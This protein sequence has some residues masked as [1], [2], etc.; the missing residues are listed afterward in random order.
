MAPRV[1]ASQLWPMFRLPAQRPG[2]P[3]LKK[4]ASGNRSAVATKPQ[5]QAAAA[6]GVVATA[7]GI[8][9]FAVRPLSSAFSCSISACMAANCFATAGGMSGSG[10]GTFAGVPGVAAVA[11]PRFPSSAGR[12][13]AAIIVW[14]PVFCAPVVCAPLSARPLSARPFRPVHCF[15]RHKSERKYSLPVPAQK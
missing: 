1:R 7:A 14:A 2:K 3:A 9:S 15:A 13:A 12:T 5:S 6:A 4:P 11:S 8:D 10:A